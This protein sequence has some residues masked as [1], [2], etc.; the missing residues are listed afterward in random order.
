MP[1]RY[2]QAQGS[3]LGRLT[4]CCR[5]PWGI[6]LLLSSPYDEVQ[7]VRLLFSLYVCALQSHSDLERS[8]KQELLCKTLTTL[9]DGRLM[10]DHC[11]AGEGLLRGTELDE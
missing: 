10:G 8:L 5:L 6:C 1:I 7:C 3:V 11:Y 2:Y 9:L 4:P